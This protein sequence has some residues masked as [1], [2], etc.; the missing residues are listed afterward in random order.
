MSYRDIATQVKDALN[1]LTR[2]AGSGGGLDDYQVLN[3]ELA[4]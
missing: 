2:F 1:N 4:L 3:C